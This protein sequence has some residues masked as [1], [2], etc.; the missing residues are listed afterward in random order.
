[1]A[2]IEQSN[3]SGRKILPGKLIRLIRM[4]KVVVEEGIQKVLPGQFY[5]NLEHDFSSNMLLFESVETAVS[6][7]VEY[8]IVISK[9]VSIFEAPLLEQQAL[10]STGRI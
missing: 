8:R 2:Y 6:N 7:S 9:R 5:S 1:L 3:H 10:V 4:A